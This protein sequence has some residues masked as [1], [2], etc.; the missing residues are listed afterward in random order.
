[1]QMAH[2]KDFL[3]SRI[4]SLRPADEI[5]YARNEFAYLDVRSRERET[6]SSPDYEEITP[7]VW[8]F[9]PFRAT[10]ER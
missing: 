5:L 8:I 4:Y 3:C 10:F 7:P 9:M 1:M 6:E 2:L